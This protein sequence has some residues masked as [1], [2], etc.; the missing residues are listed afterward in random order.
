MEIR[1]PELADGGEAD[2]VLPLWRTSKEWISH[3]CGMREQLPSLTM[4]GLRKTVRTGRLRT[5]G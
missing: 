5:G 4:M 2:Q 1:K 3:T